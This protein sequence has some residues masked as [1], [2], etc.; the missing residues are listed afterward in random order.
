MCELV[1]PD[2]RAACDLG[3]TF[4]CVLGDNASA[5]RPY[6]WVAKSCRGLFRLTHN[7]VA[8]DI[9]CGDY[10]TTGQ[11][12]EAT[13]RSCGRSCSLPRPLT[14]P[15]T[16][17]S[18]DCHGP[19]LVLPRVAAPVSLP[20]LRCQYSLSR[21]ALSTEAPACATVDALVNATATGRYDSDG[22]FVT[23]CTIP[24][25][26]SLPRGGRCVHIMGDSY[27]RHMLQT[28]SMVLKDNFVSGGFE[29][30]NA[31][32]LCDGQFSE[33][34][35][36]RRNVSFPFPCTSVEYDSRLTCRSRR[37][38]NAVRTRRGGEAAFVWLQGGLHY[39]QGPLP[40]S[41]RPSLRAPVKSFLAA[42]RTTAHRHVHANDRFFVSGL[43]FQTPAADRVFPHQRRALAQEF[44]RQARRVTEEVGGRFVDFSTVADGDEARGTSDGVHYLTSANLVKARIFLALLH[45]T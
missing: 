24:T 7:T 32:C 21:F 31:N 33:L 28:V 44:N 15:L 16:S 10:R 29:R 22:R 17:S 43:H 20:S 25:Y 11:R 18:R 39:L 5:R 14:S 6:V 9:A 4:G 3:R 13:E 19:N 30:P 36:C 34:E 8:C 37:C 35:P 45:M 38:S 26:A 23:D 42:I 27:T 2:S 41:G 12:C 40:R 1:R